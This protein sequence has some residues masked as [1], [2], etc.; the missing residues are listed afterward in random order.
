MKHF[1]HCALHTNSTVISWSFVVLSYTIVSQ[2]MHTLS[3]C[4]LSSGHWRIQDFR[5]GEARCRRHRGE[6]GL[7]RE[8][9]PS[10][11]H[12]EF[13]PSI[14]I[15]SKGQKWTRLQSTKRWSNCKHK[16]CTL[17]STQPLVSFRTAYVRSEIAR[18]QIRGMALFMS[19]R[20]NHP[21]G[22]SNL[23]PAMTW[24]CGW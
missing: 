24:I 2:E 18:R 7:V 22:H 10:P 17:S 15:R 13:S 23:R 21:G 14:I 5:S 1:A 19:C 20:T 4:R 9:V 8:D 11:V 6:W 12:H 3:I 16:L